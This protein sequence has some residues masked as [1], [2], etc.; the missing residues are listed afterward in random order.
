MD[1]RKRIFSILQQYGHDVYLQRRLLN[2]ESGQYTRPQFANVLEKH[3]V[4][5]MIPSSVQL[6]GVATDMIEGAVRNIEKVYWFMWNADPKKGDRVY[7]D[8]PTGREVYVIEYAYAYRGERGRIEYWAAGVVR[9]V[10]N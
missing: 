5:D 4:R 8:L 1:A 6:A 10:P 2:H 3:T 9:S 7:E